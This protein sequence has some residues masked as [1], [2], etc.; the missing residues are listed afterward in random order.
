M[1]KSSLRF[2]KKLKLH[3]KITRDF[4][5]LRMENFQ[6]IVLYGLEHIV[7]FSNLHQCTFKAPIW[8]WS[9][10]STSNHFFM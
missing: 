1:L 2:K 3:G 10:M 9:V 5:G 4:L 8:R 7:K 6:C